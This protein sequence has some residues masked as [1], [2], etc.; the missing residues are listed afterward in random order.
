MAIN[1][2][3]L[4]FAYLT[5]YDLGEVPGTF[6]YITNQLFLGWS[7]AELICVFATKEHR[8]I[9]DLLAGSVVVKFKKE[10]VR[11]PQS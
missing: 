3:T 6:T 10:V 11:V 2:G 5:L 7:V 9:H 8:S 1:L 4:T